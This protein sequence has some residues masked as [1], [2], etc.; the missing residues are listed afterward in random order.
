M[1][2]SGWMYVVIDIVGFLALGGA[3]AYGAYMWRN[4]SRDPL[5]KQMSDDATRRMYR[6]LPEPDN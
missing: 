1:D 4:R 6:E 3:I 5:V 2:S